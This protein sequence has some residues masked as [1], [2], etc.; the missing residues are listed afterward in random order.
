MLFRFSGPTVFSNNAWYHVAVVYDGAN[1]AGPTVTLYV[2]GTPSTPTTPP[3]PPSTITPSDADVYIA[4]LPNGGSLF[5]GMIDEVAV[6]NR[7]LS[8][9]EIQTLY[10]ATS[11]L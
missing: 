6:W 2:N 7:A 1:A 5:V 4:N 8:P 3:P 11:E 9:Q 10:T